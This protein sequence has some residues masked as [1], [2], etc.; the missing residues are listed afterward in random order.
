M[1]MQ[2]CK[3]C[4]KEISSQASSCPH[5]GAPQKKGTSKIVTIGGGFIVLCIILAVVG[6][7]TTGE[8]QSDTSSPS[9][10]S[11][12]DSIF[13]SCTSDDAG[14]SFKDVFNNGQYART[15][16]LTAIDVIDQKKISGSTGGKKLVCQ[17]TLM[18]N[19]ADKVP[20]TFTFT[21]AKDGQFY[22]EGEPIDSHSGQ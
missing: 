14:N 21:P 15:M 12:A 9:T 8:S 16:N 5:C 7:L 18:L 6:V 11:V 4:G 10:S 20:F 22:I 19:N 17:A 3:E 1:A 13:P 2:T